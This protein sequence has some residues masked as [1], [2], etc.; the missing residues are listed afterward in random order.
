MPSQIDPTWLALSRLRRRRFTSC[1]SVCT[2]ILS[3]SPYDKAVWSLKSQALSLEAYTDETEMEEEGVGEILL[4]DN[5]VATLPRPGTSLSAPRVNTSSMGIRPLSSSGRPSTGFSRPGS[6]SI[7]PMSGM[8]VDA[9]FKGPKPG[10]ARPMTTLGREVRLGTASM[11]NS[12][13]KFIE[14]DKVRKREREEGRNYIKPSRKL[15]KI[16]SKTYSW[17]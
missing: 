3:T 14:V 12:G 9:A 17:T 16:Y 15:T 13:G 11:E 6:S 1:I 5:A 8:T 4:D 7:R 2:S 10:T